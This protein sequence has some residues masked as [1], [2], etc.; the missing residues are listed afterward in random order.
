MLASQ[1]CDMAIKS[2][3]SLLIVI[4]L[5]LVHVRCVILRVLAVFVWFIS[6]YN[7][8]VCAERLGHGQDKSV[9]EF[10]YDCMQI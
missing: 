5:R 8:K 3:T 7:F 10:Q 4:V 2:A 9:V 6:V 1:K